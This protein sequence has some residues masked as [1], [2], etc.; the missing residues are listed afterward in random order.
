MGRYSTVCDLISNSRVMTNMNYKDMTMMGVKPEECPPCDKCKCP[1]CGCRRLTT[2]EIEALHKVTGLVMVK[3]KWQFGNIKCDVKDMKKAK[4]HI[5]ESDV[6]GGETA[7]A[8]A[9]EGNA[10]E[11]TIKAAGLLAAITLLVNFVN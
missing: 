10:A 5:L 8:N 7:M 2:Y 4:K 11:G 6:K 3:N 1:T 9:T